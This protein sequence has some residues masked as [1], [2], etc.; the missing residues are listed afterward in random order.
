MINKKK[1]RSSS[2][3]VDSIFRKFTKSFLSDKLFLKIRYRLK[4]GH[5][6]DL[7]NPKSFTEKIQWL[8]LYNRKTEYTSLVDKV[9]VKEFVKK[10]IGEEYIIPTIDIFNNVDD[11]PWNSL[12]E[13][14]VIKTTH[15]GGG[16]GVVICSDKTKL[17]L[18][19]AKNLLSDSLK[20]DIYKFYKEWPYKNV[21]KKIIVEKLIDSGKNN[22]LK[23][24]KFF[25]FNGEP[26][27]LKVDFGRYTEHHANYYDLN[28]NLLPYGETG[29]EPLPE[30]IEDKPSNFDKMIEIARKLSADIPFLRVD[31]YNV[32][33][34]I[35]FGELTFYPGSGMIPWTREEDDLEIGKMLVLPILNKKI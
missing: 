12:P 7:S 23:D 3:I 21:P 19:R 1:K 15:G 30:H 25:C 13:K 35:Y 29:L 33:G 18:G 32:E 34:K 11:I 8:K 14:F 26:K 28:W 5:K 2:E 6:L 27:F 24:Y 10:K 17:D 31:L 22:D 4:I 16:G 20:A 9:A